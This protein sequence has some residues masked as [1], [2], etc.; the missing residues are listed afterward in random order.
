MIK[1]F[2]KKA[3]K[4]DSNKKWKNLKFAV[5]SVTTMIRRDNIHDEKDAFY[6]ALLMEVFFVFIGI[7]QFISIQNYQ[8]NYHF[9]CISFDSMR[10]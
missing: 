5:T 9:Q 4:E 7:R 8:K 6:S 3:I 1:I 10:L 2:L